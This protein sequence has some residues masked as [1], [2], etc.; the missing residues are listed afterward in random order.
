MAQSKQSES[1]YLKKKRLDG[2]TYVCIGKL[3][4]SI[5]PELVTNE[6]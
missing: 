2:F 3:D 6:V 1:Y 5:L 4:L